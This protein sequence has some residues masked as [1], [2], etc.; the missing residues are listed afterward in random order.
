VTLNKPWAILKKHSRLSL[1]KRH[2]CRAAQLAYGHAILAVVLD[3]RYPTF[4]RAGWP[5]ES[6]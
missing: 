6:R 3:A 2:H 5:S 1:A 4:A